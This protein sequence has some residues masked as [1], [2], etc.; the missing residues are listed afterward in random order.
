[1]LEMIC[2]IPENVGWVLVGAAGAFAVMLA[3]DLAKTLYQAIKCQVDD[4]YD[5]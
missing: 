1:M 2:A 4:E 3:V 5:V